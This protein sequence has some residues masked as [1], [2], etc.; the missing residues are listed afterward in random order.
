MSL[1]KKCG[2]DLL[3]ITRLKKSDPKIGNNLKKKK[4]FF[5]KNLQNLTFPCPNFRFLLNN[6]KKRC[7]NFDAM[8]KFVG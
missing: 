1:A 7:K 2:I 6:F 8:V 3:T 5:C 4:Q